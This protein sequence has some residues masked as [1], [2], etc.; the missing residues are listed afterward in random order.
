MIHAPER[1]AHIKRK[2]DETKD[3]PG[4]ETYTLK[5]WRASDLTLPIIELDNAYMAYSIGDARTSSMHF[6]YGREHPE[7]GYFFFQN[8]EDERVQTAQQDI[9]LTMVKNRYFGESFLENPVVRGREPVIITADGTIVKGNFSVAILREIGERI[10]YC[11]VLPEDATPA[12]IENIVDA[13]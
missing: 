10:L 3:Q 7:V 2:L 1:A 6:Q 4:G 13:Y 11:V 9:M 5:N 12:E 8:A